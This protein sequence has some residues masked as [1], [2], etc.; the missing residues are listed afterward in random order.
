MTRHGTD[1]RM[2][3]KELTALSPALRRV[4]DI[5]KPTI[6]NHLQKDA[7]RGLISDLK[8]TSKA[9][10]Q[11]ASSMEEMNINE[12]NGVD[13]SLEFFI[14]ILERFR[15][16][17]SNVCRFDYATS[18]NKTQRSLIEPNISKIFLYNVLKEIVVRMQGKA[19]L[20][21]PVDLPIS[22]RKIQWF[23]LFG[24]RDGF[25]ENTRI[26]FT[27]NER[28]LIGR[29]W[30]ASY[31]ITEN[32]SRFS[33]TSKMSA[34]VTSA[35]ASMQRTEQN[36]VCQYRQSLNMGLSIDVIQLFLQWD[37]VPV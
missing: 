27:Q 10:S 24:K 17:W 12:I 7:G 26:Y 11:L 33:L 1:R 3:K 16:A 31:M 5:Y 22:G 15:R 19:A 28:W 29:M 37:R 6:L 4:I 9:A 8:A 25:L 13:I 14:N 18:F 35:L 30:P 21:K 34:I 2:S 20:S 32:I 36:G 23:P